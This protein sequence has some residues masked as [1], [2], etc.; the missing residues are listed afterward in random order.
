[1]NLQ[2]ELRITGG[3]GLGVIEVKLPPK[4]RGRQ[5]NPSI[6][7]GSGGIFKIKPDTGCWV[8]Q[9]Y[10]QEE[11]RKLL[12]QL[13]LILKQSF[14]L[15]NSS[16][17]SLKDMIMLP[18]RQALEISGTIICFDAIEMMN[19]PAFRK[20]FTMS[21]L[22][23]QPMFH[24]ITLLIGSGVIRPENTDITFAI[25]PTPTFPSVMFLTR[26]VEGRKYLASFPSIFH[27][28]R[29]ASP[30]IRPRESWGKEPFPTID[31][32][33]WFPLFSGSLP[34]IGNCT[35]AASYGRG[36]N[37]GATIDTGMEMGFMPFHGSEILFSLHNANITWSQLDVQ[38]GI[39]QVQGKCLEC[40]RPICIFDEPSVNGRLS[41]RE[42]TKERN[43]DIIRR[44]EAGEKICDIARLHG[45]DE[46]TVRRA[47]RGR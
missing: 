7:L 37:E 27:G 36:T 31:T 12:E 4:K 3:S 2:D 22:P 34:S 9:S 10:W 14:E 47:I 15:L 8:S 1:M 41:S 45:V 16:R 29:L 28:A 33:N 46:N 43:Q 44:Y 24:N 39:P 38:Q 32:E 35:V 25:L 19:N 6:D 30:C 13:S 18:I 26:S 20:W 21:S 17:F 23:N 42:L 40:P 11:I 5:R